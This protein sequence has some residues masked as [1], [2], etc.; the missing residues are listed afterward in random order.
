MWR[1]TFGIPFHNVLSHSEIDPE[2][3]LNGIHKHPLRLGYCIFAEVWGNGG[4]GKRRGWGIKVVF[5]G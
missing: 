2:L 5:A 1:T 4:G 3:R